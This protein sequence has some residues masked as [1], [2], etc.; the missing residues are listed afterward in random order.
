MSR[1]FHRWMYDAESFESLPRSIGFTDIAHW[2][3]V[4]AI[5][6]RSQHSIVRSISASTGRESFYMEI[7]L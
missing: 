4:R 7:V 1:E 3:L 5:S 6:L 2:K